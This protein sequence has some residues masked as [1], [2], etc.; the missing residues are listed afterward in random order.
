MTTSTILYNNT[1][2]FRFSTGF[3]VL[4]NDKLDYNKKL[5]LIIIKP[6]FHLQEGIFCNSY[7]LFLYVSKCHMCKLQS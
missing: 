1:W 3:Q 2:K 7:D 6:K 4:L 5:G